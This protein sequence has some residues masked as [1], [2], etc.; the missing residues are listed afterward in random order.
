MFRILEER[1]DSYII[2]DNAGNISHQ[3]RTNYF[4]L[5]YLKFNNERVFHDFGGG[6]YVEE[7]YDDAIFNAYNGKKTIQIS[8]GEGISEAIA[9]DDPARYLEIFN[10]WY[11]AAVQ[12]ETIKML[13]SMYPHRID[14]KSAK[15]CYVVDEIFMVDAKGVAHFLEDGAW[16]FLCIVASGSRNGQKISLPGIKSSEITPLTMVIIAKIMFLL[17]PNSKDGVFFNQLPKAARAH[18]LELE[19]KRRMRCA[20]DGSP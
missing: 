10:E 7:T 1:G 11:D 14:M 20:S 15:G 12:T 19:E 2:E 8:D 16:K 4:D 17:N 5:K 18:V 9:N 13:F 3:L 6:L